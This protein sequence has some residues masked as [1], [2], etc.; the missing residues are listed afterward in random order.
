MSF[1]NRVLVTGASKGIGREIAVHLGAQGWSVAIH[2]GSDK[3]G[4]SECAAALGRAHSGTYQADLSVTLEAK[5]LFE[6]VEEQ[7]E[8]YAVVNNAGVYLPL[9]FTTADEESFEADWRK[10]LAI[11]LEA[12]LYICRSAVR[13]F[14]ERGGGKIVN[15][16]SRV[17]FKGEAG[18]SLYAASKAA[19]INLTRSL[20]VEFPNVGIFGIA[21]GWVDTAM[22]RDGMAERA[23]A[24]LATLPLGRM[25]SGTGLCKR[26]GLP[27]IRISGLSKR[28]SH[29]HQ[30]GKLLSLDSRGE[31]QVQ[32]LAVYGEG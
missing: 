7:G 8:L 30:R 31:A 11:N 20:A 26:C 16:A 12:P 4:A 1:Q 17:G 14:G 5:E 15:V 22:V 10:T 9:S 6:R 13:A 32:V 29:R 27:A 3:D 25:A 2:Y 19:L 23:E 28:P 21:P 18:A 24:V